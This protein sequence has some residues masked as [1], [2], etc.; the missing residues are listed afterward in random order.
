MTSLS[1]MMDCQLYGLNPAGHH[2]TRVLLHV[3]T[4]V[5]LFLVLLR[6]APE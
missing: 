4:S 2:L 6:E 1:H 3:V 5:L